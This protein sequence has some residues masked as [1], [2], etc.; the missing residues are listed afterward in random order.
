MLASIII[1]SIIVVLMLV[2]VVLGLKKSGVNKF[3]RFFT[4]LSNLLCAASA[5]AVLIAAAA[6]GAPLPLWAVVFKYVGT[7]AVAVTM[8]TV[9]L[10]L[11]PVSGAW[12]MLLL[13]GVDMILHLIIPILALV[14]FI[15]F[16]KQPMPAPAIALG[17]LPVVLYGILYCRKVVFAPDEKR[18]DDFYGFNR[19]GKWY[20]SYVFMLLGTA[21]IAV[22][23]YVI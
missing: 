23:L 11:A 12:K 4:T 19:S 1:N 6:H 17:V 18:W 7:C 21:A 16:D 9:L 2:S 15:F 3:F 22:L 20:L 10:F 5:A 13:E 14:S 8:L